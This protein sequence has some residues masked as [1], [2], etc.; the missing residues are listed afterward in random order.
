MTPAFEWSVEKHLQ[1]LTCDFNPRHPL[2]E[3][4]DVRVVV[5]PRQPSRGGVMRQHGPHHR[6]AI[7]RDRD[8]DARTAHQHALLRLARGDCVAHCLTEVG[9]IDRRRR[10][11]AEIKH[12][13]TGLLQVALQK[14][15]EVEAGMIRRDRDR[16]P[17]H[18]SDR[19]PL[20]VEASDTIS[21]AA[22]S[23]S[24]KIMESG[25]QETETKRKSGNPSQRR[26]VRPQTTTSAADTWTTAASEKA[27]P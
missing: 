23:R 18:L 1:R 12:G 27:A 25:P 22:V 24:P 4:H 15:L 5:L 14:L 13:V 26:L 8:A 20:A 11:R 7:R 3:G 21:G 9:I 17:R 10:I 2:P 6:V 16:D 19:S